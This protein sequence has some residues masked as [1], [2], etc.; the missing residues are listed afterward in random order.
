MHT[1]SREIMLTFPSR[2][3]ILNFVNNHIL[4]QKHSYIM[5]LMTES[6]LS[7]K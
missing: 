3:K 7:L 1:L 4:R 6:V 2:S 5:L